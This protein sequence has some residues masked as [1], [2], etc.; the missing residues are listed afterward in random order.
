MR[1]IE[2]FEALRNIDADV[3]YI[4]EK[5]KFQEVLNS[6]HKGN[7]KKLPSITIDSSELI[8]SD[9]M[10]AH[11]VNPVTIV[12]HGAHGDNHYLP[13]EQEIHLNIISDVS[14]FSMTMGNPSKTA[15]HLGKKYGTRLLSELSEGYIK[16]IIMHELAHWIDDS[17]NSMH[18][19]DKSAR[20]AMDAM[21]SGTDVNDELTRKLTG[22][23]NSIA[24][25]SSEEIEGQVHTVA[26]VKR[27][28]KQSDWDNMEFSDLLNLVPIL[29]ATY[30]RVDVVGRDKWVKKL[31]TRLHREGL[32]GKNMR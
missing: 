12:C 21:A 7:P 25:F 17:L 23:K 22:N 3:E 24:E 18:L 2:L 27:Q 5:G 15:I 6:I 11:K 28:M 9:C 4:Y 19:S 16:G 31:K 10:K 26:Q 14:D 20:A 8:T 32:I 30:D 13:S 1:L 29:G